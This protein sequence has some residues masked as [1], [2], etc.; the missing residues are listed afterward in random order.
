MKEPS[1][2]KDA[3]SSSTPPAK[4]R[5]AAYSGIYAVVLIAS[6]KRYVGSAADVVLRWTVH[7]YHLRRGTH[8]CQHLQRAWTKYGEKKFRFET[9]ERCPVAVLDEREQYHMDATPRGSL[10]NCQPLAR[11]ARGYRHTPETK[12][13][14]AEAAKRVSADP[15]ERRRRSL[16]AKAQH[17][18]GKLGR[19]TW[20]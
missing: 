7:R 10:M 5:K 16:R 12:R 19:Q 6:G 14:M 1:G 15:A 3:R 17:A 9:L 13:K 18:A 2:V 20:K 8:H 11:T 4:G